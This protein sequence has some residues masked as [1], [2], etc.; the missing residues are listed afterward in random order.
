MKN[1]IPAGKKR[2]DIRRF[3]YQYIKT[4]LFI[5]EVSGEENVSYVY[6]VL[7]RENSVWL[8]RELL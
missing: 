7:L 2:N 3:K 1:S 8:R 4:G 6:G 5:G